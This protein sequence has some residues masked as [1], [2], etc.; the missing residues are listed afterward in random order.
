MKTHQS[1]TGIPFLAVGIGAVVLS[2]NSP[3]QAIVTQYRISDHPDGGAR[4]PKYVLRLDGLFSGHTNDY[5]TFSADHPSI[6]GDFLTLTYDDV[7]NTIHIGGLVYGG[8]DA[9]S[10]GAYVTDTDSLW[11][12][13]FT[14]QG[15]NPPQSPGSGLVGETNNDPEFSIV[16][17]AEST[18]F[19]TGSLTGMGINS[20]V[21]VDLQDED[22][23]K[24]FSFK[25]N[26]VDNHRLN[27]PSNTAG[28]AGPDTFVGWG[29]LNH[30]GGN[31]AISADQNR[32]YPHI[33]A[34]DWLF[35]AHRNDPPHIT[36]S[37]SPEP[38]TALTG[39]LSIGAISLCTRRRCQG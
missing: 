11:W 30:D 9:G 14:Y 23:G 20:G 35:V 21:V 34:S 4:P 33:A 6:M 15:G 5:Y 37:P 2:I 18:A 39:L 16:A 27:K 38:V 19:H 29:W 7:D 1:W 22:G 24:G 31:G 13:D 12:V 36:A 28:L 8:K 3:A 26:N 17:H 32:R 25:F 10:S